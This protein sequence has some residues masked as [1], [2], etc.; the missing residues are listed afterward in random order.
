[1]DALD[2]I[3]LC[4]E[5]A[6]FFMRTYGYQQVKVQTGNLY[7]ALIESL[8]HILAWYSQAATSKPKEYIECGPLTHRGQ[9]SIF[10]PSAKALH[11]R[12]T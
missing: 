12:K 2:Q 11:M 9:P 3:P 1:M 6:E 7:L 5:K 8:Q 4:I 10:V